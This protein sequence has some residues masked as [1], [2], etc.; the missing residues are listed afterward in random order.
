MR[1]IPMLLVLGSAW[2]WLPEQPLL[3]N[4]DPELGAPPP[5]PQSMQI[6]KI[7]RV[8]KK[9]DP[10]DVCGLLIETNAS[11]DIVA[12][13]SRCEDGETKTLYQAEPG[14]PMPKRIVLKHVSRRILGH[15]IECDGIV[16]DASDGKLDLHGGGT[17]RVLFERNCLTKPKRKLELEL[18]LSR[19]GDQWKVLGED[20]Q[21]KNCM[22]VTTGMFGVSAVDLDVRGE[23]DKPIVARTRRN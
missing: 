17:S 19:Q 22:D 9:P 18:G 12:F 11:G 4:E 3:A 21:P 10:E 23:C 14:V 5:A 16:L 6:M 15:A 1:L 2:A 13:K 20:H 7:A 8:T